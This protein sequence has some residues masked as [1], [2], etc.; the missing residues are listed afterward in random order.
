MSCWKL[1]FL[2]QTWREGGESERNVIAV[3]VDI[4]DFLKLYD[5][6]L[7]LTQQLCSKT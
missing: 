7:L 5:D 4:E 1:G 3:S 6:A 2:D